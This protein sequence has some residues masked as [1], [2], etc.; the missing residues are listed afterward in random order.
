M[1]KNTVWAA[2][3]EFIAT[4]SIRPRWCGDGVGVDWTPTYP[5]GRRS[6]YCARG[7]A[8]PASA[9]SSSD[10]ATVL[11]QLGLDHE[12]LTFRFQGRDYRL[13]DVHGRVIR[14]V[15]A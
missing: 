4:L 12:K 3:C 13:T 14:D 6:S 10:P 15:L 9:T 11:H 8:G 1:P 2:D 5:S 7:D